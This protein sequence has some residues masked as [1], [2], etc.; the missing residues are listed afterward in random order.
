MSDR[1]RILAIDDE[2]NIL[3]SYRDVLCPKGDHGELESEMN[4]LRAKLFKKSAPSFSHTSFDLVTCNQAD[5]AL[6]TLERAVKENNPFAMAFV[7]IRMPLG[8]DGM[9]VAKHIRSM[10]PHIN[11]MIVTAFSDVAHM[12]I[13]YQVPPADKLFYMQKPLHSQEI[14]QFAMA[15]SAKWQA[16]IQFQKLQAELETR[17]KKRTVDLAEAND[18]LRNL[19]AHLQSVREVERK[20]I[21]REIHDEL[22][23]LL[24]ALQMDLSDITIDLPQDQKPLVEKTKSMSKL[25]DTCIQTVQRISSNLRPSILDDLGI[26]PAIEW[27]AE[28]FQTRM[29]IKC[30]FTSNA[31]NIVLDKNCSTVIYRIF[32]ETL[33]NV[34]RHANA[35]QVKANLRKESEELILKIEDNGKGITKEDMSSP[36]S[37]GIIGIKER[38]LFV[39]GK[40]EIEGDKG[41]GT[42]ITVSIPLSQRETTQ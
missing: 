27:H 2:Q 12:D 8:H 30:E 10:D 1:F 6:E 28:E 36:K 11:I 9:F 24:T 29:G 14:R 22:G 16:E 40:V 4:N 32:Q 37:F 23:Q 38:A 18:E 26:V 17:I 41:K 33:T 21:A 34:A 3:D 25:I 35:T 15:L 42:T 19:S 39:G 7:D 5:E 20:G 13:A 31:E